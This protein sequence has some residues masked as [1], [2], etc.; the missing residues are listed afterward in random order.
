MLDLL[1]AEDQHGVAHRTLL[2]LVDGLRTFGDQAFHGQALDALELDAEAVD[3][4][5]YAL[6]LGLG[7]V[8]MAGKGGGQVAVRRRLGQFG[9]GLGQLLFSA[10]DI[11]QFVDEGVFER[12]DL[13]HDMSFAGG[14][15]G[16]G[17]AVGVD[18]T[19]IGERGKAE[20]VR[21]PPRGV[22]GGDQ[23]RLPPLKRPSSSRWRLPPRLSLLSS[24]DRDR[25]VPRS[26][27]WLWLPASA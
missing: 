16:T 6:D 27:S 9:Q 1:R 11:R 24:G 4:L 19:W 18:R 12:G 3:D 23:W 14:G 15:A 10:V 25:D 7:L 5:V 26:L 21:P 2:D 22:K 13:G 20:A 17:A 8:A